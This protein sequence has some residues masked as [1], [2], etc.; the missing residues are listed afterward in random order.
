MVLLVVL[1]AVCAVWGLYTLYRTG[2]RDGY[3]AG[4]QGRPLR[5]W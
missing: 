2:Y 3:S 5:R 1:G 4:I